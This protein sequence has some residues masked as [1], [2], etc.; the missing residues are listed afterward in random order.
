[1]RGGDRRSGP[2]QD[3]ARRT[4]IIVQDDEERDA[5]WAWGVEPCQRCLSS[6]LSPSAPC[7]G[8]RVCRCPL[9]VACGCVRLQDM[10][11]RRSLTRAPASGEH[12]E[13]LRCRLRSGW[14][15]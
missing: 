7:W 4:L 6:C 5:A 9:A 10:L 14:W 11:C 8:L 1:V 13:A 15:V 2:G 12:K 3:G